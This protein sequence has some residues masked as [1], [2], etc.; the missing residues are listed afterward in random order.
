MPGSW[1]NA[2]GCWLLRALYVSPPRLWPF[3]FG[4]VWLHFMS[5]E[6]GE[7][8]GPKRL[9]EKARSAIAGNDRTKITFSSFRDSGNRTCCN[10]CIFAAHG[11]LRNMVQMGRQR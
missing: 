6:V 5:S 3:V 11:H 7:C 1:N 10:C 9:A 2:A 4:L 8:A